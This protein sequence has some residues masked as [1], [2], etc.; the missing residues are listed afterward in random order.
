MWTHSADTRDR[1]TYENEHRERRLVRQSEDD[2][3]DA[4][5]VDDRLRDDR[6]LEAPSRLVDRHAL[7]EAEH[8]LKDVPDLRFG[9]RLVLRRDRVGHAVGAIPQRNDVALLFLRR[10]ACERVDAPNALW[11]RRRWR[12]I[13]VRARTRERRCCACACCS[14]VNVDAEVVVALRI[15]RWRRHGELDD[16]HLNTERR[17]TTTAARA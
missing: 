6:E 4:E 11:L 3:E 5:R 9:T 2:R 17:A 13:I 8:A 15:V 14:S 1:G 12:S 7:E 16:L 10:R